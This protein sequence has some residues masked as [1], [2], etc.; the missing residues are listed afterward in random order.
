MK[1][2]RWLSR[3]APLAVL[4]VGASGW[5]S[6]GPITFDSALPVDEGGFVFRQQLRWLRAGDDPSGANRDMRANAAIAV[7]GYGVNAKLAVFAVL[8]YTDKTLKLDRNGTR[9][10]RDN[11]G[12]GDVT[13]FARYTLWQDDAPG[14]TLRLAGF[15]GISAATGDDDKSDR[16]GRLPPSVQDGSGAWNPFGGV[17]ASYQTLDYEIDGQLSYRDN[18]AANGFEAGDETRLDLSWQYRLWPPELAGGVPGFFYGVLEVNALHQ[19]KNRVNGQRDGNSGGDTLWLS[20]GLQYVTKRWVWE[21][22]VQKPIYQHLNGTAL[23]ND[24]IVTAGF[25]VRF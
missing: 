24:L 17:V 9:I 22:V 18:H 14:R 16:F 12:L 23:E 13:A 8:P 2:S 11:Q 20:P 19:D 7:L 3:M 1:L 10:E 15:A 5:A 25:R 21:A 6:A 4:S